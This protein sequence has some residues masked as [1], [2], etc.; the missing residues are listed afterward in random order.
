[1][2]CIYREPVF[3]VMVISFLCTG[4]M[5]QSHAIDDLYYQPMTKQELIFD[6]LVKSNKY[7][8]ICSVDSLIETEYRSISD[9]MLHRLNK[10]KYVYFIY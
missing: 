9:W 1:M 10:I 8:D 5:A 3:F 2:K 6:S 7:K 4:C